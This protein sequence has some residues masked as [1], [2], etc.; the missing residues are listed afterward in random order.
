MTAEQLADAAENR[1]LWTDQEVQRGWKPELDPRPVR[2]LALA[3]GYPNPAFYIFDAKNADEIT[4]KLLGGDKLYLDPLIWNLRPGEFTA[5]FD[6]STSSIYL[7]SGK[8]Y[9][10]DSHHRQQAILKAVRAFSPH[11]SPALTPGRGSV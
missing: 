3:D 11:F 10:P 6:D 7:Y 8:L 4:E 9:L 1:L 5:Y 2:E